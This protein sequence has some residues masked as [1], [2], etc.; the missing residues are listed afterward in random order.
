MSREVRKAMAR[1]A[2]MAAVEWSHP[3]L[4]APSHSE[5][6]HLLREAALEF[7]RWWAKQRR[8]DLE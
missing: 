8:G 1:A 2:W 5:S 6:E 4:A 7:E 3:K